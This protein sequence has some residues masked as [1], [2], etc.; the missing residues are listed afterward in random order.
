MDNRNGWQYSVLDDKPWLL[1]FANAG[2]GL[3]NRLW[4][5]RWRCSCCWWW[6]CCCCWRC[7]F[8]E[9]ALRKA[10]CHYGGLTCYSCRAFFRWWLSLWYGDDPGIDD[11][12]MMD[13]MVRRNCQR[14]RLPACRAVIK[15]KG[16]AGECEV[17]IKINI[18]KIIIIMTMI[19]Q[20]S[21]TISS[22]C[23][24]C[25]FH[26]CLRFEDFFHKLLTVASAMHRQHSGLGPWSS[27]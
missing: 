13:K 4:G 6:R 27:P 21:H 5:R 24:A 16:K 12:K 7:W 25:R 22:R 18:N 19:Y 23:I 17:N 26:Q 1:W 8:A 14:G 10:R 3:L 15:R 11:E 2:A 9:Q 20:V